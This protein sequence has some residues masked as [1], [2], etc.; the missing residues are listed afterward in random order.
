M[1]RWTNRQELTHQVVTLRR[2]G[3]GIRAIQ[4]AVGVSRNTVRKILAAHDLARQAPHTALPERPPRAPRPKK[5]DRFAQKIAE[6]LETY[7]DI[8]AQRV[9]EELREAGYDG[10]Y[11]QVKA[12]VCKVR[13]KPKPEPSYATP[14]YR[15]GE[16]SECDW[17][18]YTIDFDDGTRSV[19]ETFSYVL[20]HS[21]RKSF[22]FHEHRD[23]HALMDGHVAAFA[24]FGGVAEVCKY[25][26]QKPVVLRWEGGQPIYNPRFVAF[27][28]YYEFRPLACTRGAPNEKPHVERAFWELER[29]FL[30]GRRFRNL[31]DMRSQLR[32]WQDTICDLRVHK[33]L[34]RT[35]L[36]MFAAEEREHLKSLP[37]HAYDTARI[38]YR[39][40]SLEG[41]V[42]WDGNHYAVPYDHVTDILPV[43]ITQDELHVYGADLSRVAHH[44]LAPKSAGQYIGA[45]TCHRRKG[46]AVAD[47]DQVRQA[48]A[49]MGEDAADFFTALAAGKPR[50]CGFHARQILLLRQRYATDDICA[51]LR[52]ARDYG[53]LEHAAIARILAARAK[54]RSL[55]EYIEEETARRLEDEIGARVIAPRDLT[56]YDRLPVT[57]SEQED[58]CP[59]EDPPTTNPSSV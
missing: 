32:H 47:I 39:L 37:C 45:D 22:G 41:F 44:E 19:V 5:L 43:R 14:D 30:N 54:P 2:E 3:M 40:C 10:G 28:T 18:P 23:L 20:C 29:S 56:E 9:F 31:D 49:Q 4:R 15:P 24:R 6:L 36:E 58:T 38:V 26:S 55:A 59:D 50:L 42:A 33:K 12:H 13:P 51:A 46:Q 17:S 27:A 11:T 1:Q 53:A 34:K 21:R 8:T 25:D 57:T 52:H 7:P 48:F 16:M 35:A